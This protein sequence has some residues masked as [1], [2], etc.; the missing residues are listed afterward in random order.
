MHTM[1]VHSYLYEI[2]VLIL[3]YKSHKSIFF[4]N[5]IDKNRLNNKLRQK[6]Q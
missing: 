1:I 6:Y 2:L 5:L 3:L 4:N